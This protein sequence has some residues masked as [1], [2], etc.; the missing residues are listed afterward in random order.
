VAKDQSRTILVAPMLAHEW[1]EL[2]L[3]TARI[4]ALRARYH[5]AREARHVGLMAGLKEELARARR[6][7]EQVL[8]HLAVRMGS[9]A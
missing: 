3:L 9:E 1:E 6:M 5:D 8:Q 7:R 4:A 2:E